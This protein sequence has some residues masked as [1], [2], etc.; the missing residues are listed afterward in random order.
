MGLTDDLLKGK[1]P[2]TK[3]SAGNIIQKPK[4]LTDRLLSGDD[5]TQPPKNNRPLST[6]GQQAEKFDWSFPA[7]LDRAMRGQYAAANLFR[8]LLEKA[9]G[10]K[11]EAEN[12]DAAMTRVWKGLTGEEKGDFVENILKA[13]PVEIDYWKDKEKGIM[14]SSNSV[15][16]ESIGKDLARRVPGFALNIM[17][18]PISYLQIG[19]L[20]KAGRSAQALK[21]AKAAGIDVTKVMAGKEIQEMGSTLGQQAKLGQR[22]LLSF[23]PFKLTPNVLNE[24]VYNAV[25]GVN[26]AFG[27]SIVGRQ[28]SKLFATRAMNKQVRKVQDLNTK[29]EDLFKFLETGEKN[30]GRVLDHSIRQYAKERGVSPD[31]IGSL[32]TDLVQK[33]EIREIIAERVPTNFLRIP[34][35]NPKTGKPTGKIIKKTY[36]IPGRRDLKQGDL[37]SRTIKPVG[38]SEKDVMKKFL[39]PEG[40]SYDEL[41]RFIVMAKAAKAGKPIGYNMVDIHSKEF[42][43]LINIVPVNTPGGV[44]KVLNELPQKGLAGGIKGRQRAYLT[45]ELRKAL[46]E[47]PKLQEYVLD[48]AYK[49]FGVMTKTIDSRYALTEEVIPGRQIIKELE[50]TPDREQYLLSKEFEQMD[51][52]AAKYLV[53]STD[54]LKGQSPFVKKT[55]KQI[56]EQNRKFLEKEKLLNVNIDELPGDIEYMLHALTKEARDILDKEYFKGKVN[57]YAMDHASTLKRSFSFLINKQGDRIPLTELTTPQLDKAVQMGGRVHSLTIGEINE[58]ARKG[59]LDI[60]NGKKVMKFFHDDPALVQ[61]IRG[62][63]HSKAVSNAEF[64]KE[65][66]MFGLDESKIARVPDGYTTI[67]LPEF[68][69]HVFPSEVAAHITKTAIVNRNPSE[70][71]QIAKTFDDVQNYWKAWT[72]APIPSY[73][74]RNMA[75]NIWNNYLGDVTNPELYRLAAKVQ[76]GDDAILPNLVT[77]TF[78]KMGT[79]LTSGARG[80]IRTVHGNKIPLAEIREQAQK[81]GV[82]GLGFYAADLPSAI[83]SELR[84]GNLLSKDGPIIRSGMQMGRFLEN[85]ARYAHFI[86]KVQKGNSF[87]D[88]ARS[89]KKFLFDYNDLTEFEKKVMKRAFPFYTWTRKNIPLQLEGMLKQPGKFISIEK[90][91]RAIEAGDTDPLDPVY[92]SEYVKE[93]YPV[94]MRGKGGKKEFFLLGG[95]IPATDVLKLSRPKDLM[96]GLLSPFIRTPLE[97]MINEN[98]FFGKDEQTA[99]GGEL[100]RFR[101]EKTTFLGQAINKR[102]NLGTLNPAEVLEGYAVRMHEQGLGKGTL[103]GTMDAVGSHVMSSIRL[104]N[105]VDRLNPGGMFGTKEELEALGYPENR[106][107]SRPTWFRWLDFLTGMKF[108]EVV[109]EEEKQKHMINNISDL[110]TFKRKFVGKV[111][112]G[113]QVNADQLLSMMLDKA[114][115]LDEGNQ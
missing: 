67:D 6:E 22:A 35:V 104:I 98:L 80:S 99:G 106:R 31:E 7:W 58:M 29:Y 88:A 96:L 20:T 63:R 77:R 39:S 17:T 60:L 51:P 49:K 16:W 43:N 26:Q 93:N 36:D 42:Q 66:K 83:N 11:L 3:A 73:H 24:K 15:F 53:K 56:A 100:E 69:G 13:Y 33:P 89:V 57:K 4:G 32:I 76:L 90:V 5:I 28:L 47:F 86:D 50:L 115:N 30:T 37:I 107:A 59:K 109:P 45:G 78:R 8:P 23:G 87:E 91:K 64:V 79:L 110:K 92:L 18:D 82:E 81:L 68:K 2:A 54:R 10:S 70:M 9:P 52:T 71:A 34:E 94:Q 38:T 75:G 112:Q 41:A 19:N 55:V 44:K 114:N 101:G 72:L 103:Y 40:S 14:K 62:V 1:I 25:E 21:G 85:N 27:N 113:D 65:V 46:N 97:L 74:V 105:E 12:Q 48:H 102:G 84:H 95:W 108:E 61:T 111:L